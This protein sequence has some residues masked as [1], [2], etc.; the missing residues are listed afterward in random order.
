MPPARCPRCHLHLAHCFCPWLPEPPWTLPG[1]RELVV[2]R[3]W[4]EAR[5]PTST[6]VLA[7]TALQP[8]RVLDYGDW[9]R[10]WQPEALPL[11]GAALLFPGNDDCPSEPLSPENAPQRLI[12]IDGTWPQA[13]RMA[14]RVPGFKSL[15]RRE[16]HQPARPVPRLRT[17]HADWAR[18][19][20][21]AIADAV[22]VLGDPEL[23]ERL[24]RLHGLFVQATLHQRGTAA[25]LP[26]PEAAWP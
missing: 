11:D 7:A 23:G 13:R 12:V 6:G 22:A 18:A 16:I 26:P 3:H 2:V 21:E 24:H 17:P 20:I 1:G 10:P 9:D 4:K 5:K 8:S 19:T 14:R 25:P 15:P